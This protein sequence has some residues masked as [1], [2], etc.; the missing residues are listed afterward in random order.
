MTDV[1]ANPVWAAAAGFLAGVIVARLLGV[2]G[3]RSSDRKESNNVSS[4]NSLHYTNKVMS[5]KVEEA[6]ADLAS[7]NA[8]IVQRD[9]DIADLRTALEAKEAQLDKLKNDLRDSVGKTHE[10]RREL[11]ERAEDTVR[12]QV[13]ARDMANELDVLQTSADLL[14]E[15]VLKDIRRKDQ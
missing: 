5:R 6:E 8:D 7:A 10:L 13:E 11:V 1:L 14:D 12:A 9:R 3:S 15:E 2:F 4:F